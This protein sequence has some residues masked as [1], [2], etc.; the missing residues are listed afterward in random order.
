MRTI[1]EDLDDLDRMLDGD[2]PKDKVRSQIRLISREVAALEADYTRLAQSHQHE[3]ASMTQ[4][5]AEAVAGLQSKNQQLV[6]TN[7]QLVAKITEL[8]G[9]KTPYVQGRVGSREGY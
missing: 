3:V 4:A 9:P 8:E 6:A 2:A 5:H 1:H 7:E